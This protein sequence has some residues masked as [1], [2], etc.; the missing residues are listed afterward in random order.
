MQTKQAAKVFFFLTA[1]L[2]LALRSSVSAE[3]DPAEAAFKNIGE[4]IVSLDKRGEKMADELF[5]L[6]SRKFREGLKKIAAEN[7][8]SVWADDAQYLVAQLMPDVERAY[9]EREILL[10][11]WPDPSFEEWT[12]ENLD[13]LLPRVAPAGLAVRLQLCMDYIQLEKMDSLRALAEASIAKYPDYSNNFEVF[14][15]AAEQEAP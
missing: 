5:Y 12:R 6:E 9:K 1:L 13:F 2:C 8:A 10:K 15:Q 4:N 14:L 11:D 3:I 7:A